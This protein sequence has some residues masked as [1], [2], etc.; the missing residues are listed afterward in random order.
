[1]VLPLEEQL[2]DIL[3]PV[4]QGGVDHLSVDQPGAPA[5]VMIKAEQRQDWSP[6]GGGRQQPEE[7]EDLDFIV[8]WKPEAEEEVGYFLRDGDDG[9][10]DPVGHPV[11]I[12]LRL[13]AD[14]FL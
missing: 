10:H 5:K 9:E 13:G 1:M 8:E 7:E 11:D 3:L 14:R 12:V 2:V 6:P 4:E